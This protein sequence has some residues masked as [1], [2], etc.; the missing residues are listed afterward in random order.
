V[1][2][3][4][5]A[6]VTTALRPQAPQQPQWSDPAQAHRVRD[7][8]AARPPLV[9]IEDVRTL[10]SLLALVAAGEAHIIQAGD[11]AED[12]GDCT[13]EH[14]IRKCA[15]LDQ[16]AY[17]LSR[18]TGK[19]VL[20]VGRIAGQFAKPRSSATE[21]V[22]GRELPVFRGHMVNGPAPD[23][24]ARAADPLRILSCYMAAR[25]VMGQLGWDGPAHS[26]RQW[27]EPPVWTSHE[28]L[29]LDYEEPMIRDLGGGER[30]LGSTHWP[31]IGERTRQVD[32]AHV[33]LLEDIVNPV[34]CKIGPK[35][36]PAEIVALCD[37][38]DPRRE[39]GALTLIARMG[40]GVAG[41]RLPRLVEAVRHAGHPVIW[42][43]DPMHG[44]TISG[45]GGRKVR[46]VDTIM[47]EVREFRQAVSAGGGTA[48]GLHLEATPE[49]VTECVADADALGRTELVSTSLCDPRLNAAQAVSVVAAWSGAQGNRDAR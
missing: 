10:R 30:W 6:P 15:L 20:R 18:A 36:D 31:W 16:L 29:I 23:P 9:R 7:I 32:G 11:C 42:L 12:P 38:L 22:D 44:N 45:P 2:D 39:P 43:S 28:A 14:I 4:V 40:A 46:L 5:A 26:L 35:T 47:R 21:R 33:A 49:E 37:R 24:A 48:G 25:E 8:L 34:A 1:I 3:P 27:I 19:P 41:E 13:P 17:T